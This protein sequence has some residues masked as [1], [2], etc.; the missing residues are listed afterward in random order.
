MRVDPRKPSIMWTARAFMLGLFAV[1]GASL[2]WM[3]E[4][5]PWQLPVSAV[6][7]ALLAIA[8]GAMRDV[9]LD[10]KRGILP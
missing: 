9:Q 4:L 8:L 1:V 3:W 2:A 5:V 6:L 7:L 10:R